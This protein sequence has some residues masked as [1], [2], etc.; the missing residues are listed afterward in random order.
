MVAQKPH[1]PNGIGRITRPRTE[2]EIFEDP[3]E[4]LRGFQEGWLG[5]YEKTGKFDWKKYPRPR[6]RFAPRGPGIN[7]AESR[8]LFVTTAGAYLPASQKPFDAANPFGDYSI[9]QFPSSTPF[10][11]ISYAHEH[12]DQ[13]YV[14]EDPQVLLPLRHLEDMVAE[15]KIGEIAPMVVSFSGYQPNIIRIVKEMIPAI[16]NVARELH[17]EAALLVPA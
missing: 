16:L 12:Y 7:L 4:W 10:E 3:K 8:L 15:G 2:M 14:K 11:E 9:R 13:T 5:A 1:K 17:A 6:N